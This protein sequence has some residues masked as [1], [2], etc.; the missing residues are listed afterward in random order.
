MAP[1]PTTRIG[2]LLIDHVQLL[3]MSSIDLFGM[4]SP[5]YLSPLFLP[6]PLK[7]GAVPM[8]ILYIDQAGPNTLHEC[9][10]KAGLR[11]DAS[12]SDNICSPPKKGEEKTL[13]VLLIP[14]P[15][16]W[17]YKPTDALNGFIK[18]HFDSGTDVL[19]VCTG[20]IPAGYA[21]ILKGKR[22]TGPRALLPDLKK[23][24]PEAVWEDKRWVSDGNLWNSAGV[25]TGQ[26]MVAAYIREKWPGP[27]AEAILAMAE[28]GERPQEYGSSKMSDNA[29]WLWT[30][31]RAW[32][33]PYKK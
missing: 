8:E 25:T 23:R 7:A 15:D 5:S 12:I 17:A 28:V 11:I 20:V 4:L 9:T 13:D 29:W 22:V 24:L 10:A 26:D 2:V 1:K 30:V 31:V 16:P 6:S 33:F 32:A 18:G 27:T 21:G 19:T 14:G 3:D